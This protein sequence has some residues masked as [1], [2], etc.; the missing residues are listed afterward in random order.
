MEKEIVKSKVLVSRKHFS[1]KGGQT[2][3]ALATF[4]VLPCF[5][6]T[7]FLAANAAEQ[8]G[9][10]D[11]FQKETEAKLKEFNRKVEELKSKAVEL[12][13]DAKKEFDEL[14]EKLKKKQEA[15]NK[16]LEKLKSASDKTWEDLKSKTDSAMKELE[17]LYDRV[18]SKFK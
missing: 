13:G 3:K 10:K 6:F 1:R 4:I 5:I 12:K 14:L 15:A 8:K 18:A 11:E 17:K 7:V 16:K 2:M 9:L